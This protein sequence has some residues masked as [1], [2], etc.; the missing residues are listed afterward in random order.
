LRCRRAVT[1]RRAFAI[2]VITVVESA[3]IAVGADIHD[4]DVARSAAATATSHSLAH[5][6]YGLSGGEA[7]HQFGQIDP[8]HALA[9]NAHGVEFESRDEIG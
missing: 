2:L 3:R 8:L 7:Q 4:T 9:V 5:F 1:V 6:F